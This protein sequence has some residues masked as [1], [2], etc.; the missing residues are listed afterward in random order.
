MHE[1][2]EE[3]EDGKM[4]VCSTKSK[5]IDTLCLGF[6]NFGNSLGSIK[7]SFGCFLKSKESFINGFGMRSISLFLKFLLNPNYEPLSW[8]M[9]QDILNQ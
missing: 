6:L 7:R 4:R 8:F 1:K 5:N 9:I 3:E 2:D